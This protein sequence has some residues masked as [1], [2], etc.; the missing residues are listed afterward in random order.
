[1]TQ[2]TK[3]LDKFIKLGPVEP[4]RASLDAKIWQIGYDKLS[5][6][7]LIC[8]LVNYQDIISLSC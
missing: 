6:H 1:M 3:V 2:N 8:G 5:C 4:L 7:L